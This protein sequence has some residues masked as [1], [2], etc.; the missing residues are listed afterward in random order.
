MSIYF[1]SDL[2]LSPYRP[3]ISQLFFQFLQHLRNVEKLFILGDLFDAWIGDDAVSP[4]MTAVLLEIKSLSQ[5]G[6]EVYFLRGNRDFLVGE[7]FAEM[8]A[9]H[10]LK[11]LTVMDLYG[12][13]TLLCHGDILCSD[14]VEYQQFRT[15]V[16]NPQWQTQFLALPVEKRLEMARQMRAKSSAMTAMK[17][18]DIMDVNQQTVAD[19][20]H[21]YQ[22]QRLIHGHTHRTGIHKFSLQ[23]HHVERI[24]LGDWR[25]NFG[26]VLRVGAKE[27]TLEKYTPTTPGSK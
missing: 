25:D 20:F 16:R 17:P 3:A 12:T 24:V 9:C 21:K 22:V 13:K 2:H 10:L 15:T 27:Y 11:D 7:Q 8:T 14:D 23:H 19:H 18:E 26:S 5:K 1:I 6:I 4:E